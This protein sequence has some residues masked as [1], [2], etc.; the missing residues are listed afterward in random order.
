MEQS[1]ILKAGQ[2][3]NSTM[4]T[5][6]AS[7]YEPSIWLLLDQMV[8]IAII[9]F[10]IA[11]VCSQVRPRRKDSSKNEDKQSKDDSNNNQIKSTDDNSKTAINDET[12][13]TASHQDV[14][15]SS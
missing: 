4:A 10:M 3:D 5:T 9:I 14:K 15:A 6:V 13:N 1:I 11:L 2:A 7:I 12:M 8:S